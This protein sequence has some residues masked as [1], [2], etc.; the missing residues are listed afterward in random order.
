MTDHTFSLQAQGRTILGKKAKH[1]RKQGILPANI[2][3]NVDKSVPVQLQAKDFRKIYSEAG[4]TGLI[5]LQLGEEKITR[6]V[7]VDSVDIDPFSQQLL[8]VSLRQVNLKE[9]I[10]AEVGVEVVGE[11]AVKD[12]QYVLLKDA[13]EVEALPT[14][15][16]EGF[17]ID[18]TQFT[19]IG[20][21]FKVSD[22][23]VD[24]SKVEV[25]AEPDQVLL[26]VQELELMSEEE[27]MPAPEGP[28]VEGADGETTGETPAEGG[29]EETKTE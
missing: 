25:M 1:L 13:L 28:V 15:L 14:D 7:L 4:E 18:L 10:T 12:A 27:P 6:P 20:Q 29:V 3:G 5:H 19:E 17:E 24:R 11:L 26:Q 22:L 23:A 2:F 16:P 9:K 21:E 8:H